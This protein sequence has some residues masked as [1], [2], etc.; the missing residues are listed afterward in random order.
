MRM[1]TGETR[2]CEGT[3]W[4]RLLEAKA[5]TLSPEAARSLLE[6]DFTDD[7][8]VRMHDLA[9]KAKAGTVTAAEQEEIEDYGKVGSIL[10]VLHSKARVAL[11]NAS[12]GSPKAHQ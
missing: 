7:D 11:R 8:R 12:N 6:L 4:G 5:S 9:Q 3:I 1:A 10:A 2:N